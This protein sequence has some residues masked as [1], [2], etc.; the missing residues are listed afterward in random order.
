[1]PPRRA[2]VLGFVAVVLFLFVVDARRIF[3]RVVAGLDESYEAAQELFQNAPPRP[4]RSTHDRQRGV[5]DR[6]GGHGDL[7]P[8]LHHHRPRSGGYRRLHRAARAGP[9]PR[10][11][12]ARQWRHAAGTGGTG[13]GRTDP[14]GRVRARG[15]DRGQPHGHRLDRSRPAGPGR[16]HARRRHRHGRGAVFLPAI[17]AGA[18]PR[19]QHRAGTG[20]RASG[21]RARVLEDPAG[22]TDVRASMSTD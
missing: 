12:R 21:C 2:N 13:A 18:D 7:R 1:M 9:D 6:L 8:R 3:D 5:L 20:D 11:C 4:D 22:R 14:P 17:A 16:I 19:N 10:L 15:A